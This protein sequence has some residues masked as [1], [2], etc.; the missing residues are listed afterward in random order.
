MA[1]GVAVPDGEQPEPSAELAEAQ[2]RVMLAEIAYAE[3]CSEA[4][5]I[6]S[7]I[8]RGRSGPLVVNQPGDLVELPASEYLVAPAELDGALTDAVQH[9]RDVGERLRE[10]RRDERTISTRE[11]D[12]RRR[13][14]YAEQ[15][16]ELAAARSNRGTGER[17]VG[18]LERIRGTSS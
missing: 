3:A 1:F 9:V 8:L 14:Q 15:Q 7:A 12:E 4:Q 6:R 11:S 13:S 16:L 17:R 18:V 10:A 2:L 5:E